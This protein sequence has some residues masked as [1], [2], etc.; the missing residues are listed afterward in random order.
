MSGR[1]RRR[2]WQRPCLGTA[3]VPWGLPV[4]TTSFMRTMAYIHTGFTLRR[5]LA[6]AGE[7]LLLAVVNWRCDRWPLQRH[8]DVMAACLVVMV[9][10]AVLKISGPSPAD[11]AAFCCPCVEFVVHVGGDE[12]RACAAGLP[13]GAIPTVAAQML[14][15]QLRALAF[16]LKAAAR[17]DA[18]HLVAVEVHAAP[19]L[20]FLEAA[21]TCTERAWRDWPRPRCLIRE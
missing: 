12:L 5:L 10:H 1:R 21:V 16:L 13:E 19:V 6:E 8:W 7:M 9:G 14:V 3:V 17:G 2:W 4:L 11:V 18:M 15:Y 20:L